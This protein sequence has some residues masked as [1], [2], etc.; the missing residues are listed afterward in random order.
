MVATHLDPCF[1][2][3]HVDNST[4]GLIAVLVDDSLLAGTEHFAEAET[5]MHQQFDMG[6]TSILTQNN[7]VKFGGVNIIQTEVYLCLCQQDYIDHIGL[8]DKSD[9]SI[10]NIRKGRDVESLL[11]L[12]RGRDQI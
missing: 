4:D 12:R 10:T 5:E 8:V 7:S 9:A 1:L 2:Y 3:R 11:G 6:S